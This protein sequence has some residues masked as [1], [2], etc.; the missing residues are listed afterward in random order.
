M[1]TPSAARTLAGILHATHSADQTRELLAAHA[2]EVLAENAPRDQVPPEVAAELCR[3]D[4]QLLHDLFAE[5]APHDW[6]PAQAWESVPYAVAGEQLTP[7]QIAA[8]CAAGLL[9][10]HAPG[11]VITAPMVNAAI[12]HLHTTMAWVRANTGQQ[13]KPRAAAP[14]PALMRELVE[15]ARAQTPASTSPLC[16]DPVTLPDGTAVTCSKLAGHPNDWHRRGTSSW[17]TV[18]GT[19]PGQHRY[20][21]AK[22]DEL[23]RLRTVVRSWRTALQTISEQ[24]RTCCTACDTAQAA[25]AQDVQNPTR[26]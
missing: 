19:P 3:Q 13:D 15:G 2:A 1:S 16:A 21:P 26:T 20:G 9:E 17:K 8:V 6:V 11:T 23:G 24:C 10:H 22:A 7:Q 5:N 18:F 12:D 4:L 14:S 25:L